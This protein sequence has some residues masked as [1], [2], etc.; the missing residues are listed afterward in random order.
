MGDV[1]ANYM[2]CHSRATC[3]IAG[4][5]HLAKSMS[6]SCHIARCNNSIRHIENRFS[7]Y[8]IFLMQFGFWRAA[9]IVSSPIHLFF[10]KLAHFLGGLLFWRALYSLLPVA[11]V[12]WKR[13]NSRN[14]AMNSLQLRR[15][16]RQ[17]FFAQTYGRY[18]RTAC[19]RTRCRFS[20]TRS[21]LL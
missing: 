18:G 5:C 16:Y 3:H 1:W 11:D 4:C 10:E 17:V 21:R 7:P 9:A 15:H 20:T 12:A 8:C 6:W 14:A 2:A 19:L 13:R